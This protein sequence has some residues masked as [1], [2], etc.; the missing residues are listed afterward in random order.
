MY[1]I[2]G[3]E[4]S[5]LMETTSCMVCGKENV[6]LVFDHCHNKKHVRG[7]LCNKCNMGLGHFND[8][9]GNL[10]SAIEYLLA[11]EEV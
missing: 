2:S 5:K 1:K 9:I 3:E 4:Y 11:T 7:R 10:L 6:D 8:D